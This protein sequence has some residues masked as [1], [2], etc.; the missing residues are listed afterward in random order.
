MLNEKERHFFVGLSAPPI[1]SLDKLMKYRLHRQQGWLKTG[2]T[3]GVKVSQLA[4]QSPGGAQS[5]VLW[6]WGLTSSLITWMI[7]HTTLSKFAVGA[8]LGGVP[9]RPAGCTVIQSDLK[10]QEKWAERKPMKS[11]NRKWNVLPQLRRNRP[12]HQNRVVTNCLE[13]HSVEKDLGPRWTTSLPRACSAP[14]Q[15]GQHHP[16]L[17]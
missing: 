14:L 5:L 17:Y 9:D 1:K 6:P 4:V 3:P 10:R 16:V 15:E 12:M 7:G 8:E 11:N 13:S 2:Q